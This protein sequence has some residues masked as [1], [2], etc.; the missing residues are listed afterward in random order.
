MAAKEAAE[1]EGSVGE[2]RVD[3]EGSGRHGSGGEKAGRE[4]GSRQGNP[5][6]MLARSGERG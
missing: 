2:A 1:V 6:T 3:G 5:G 4:V